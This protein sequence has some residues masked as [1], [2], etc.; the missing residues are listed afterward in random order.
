MPLEDP[1]HHPLRRRPRHPRVHA[2]RAGPRRQR[3]LARPAER[4]LRAR[5]HPLPPALGPPALRGH[6]ARR[7]LAWSA[8]GPPA[9]ALPRSSSGR[10]PVPAELVAICERAMRR[11]IAIATPAPSRSRGTSWPSSTAR[12]RREQALARARSGARAMEPDRWPRERG[13]KRRRG[14]RRAARRGAALRSDR[15]EAPG[16]GAR[17]RGRPARPRVAALARDAVAPG[18][19]RRAHRRP[20]PARGARACSPT[21]TASASRRRSWPPGRGRGALRGA[22]PRPRPR[23]ARSLP[24]RRGRDTLVTDPPGAEVIARALRAAR[25]PARARGPAGML[26]R[27]PLREVP[28]SSGGATGSGCARRD[29]PRCSIRC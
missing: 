12:E 28:L 4:R 1:G 25:P 10:P 2:A 3:D 17:G 19:A 27:T 20:G 29:G 16:V 9:A 24:P 22:P 6:A 18:R 5:R 23:P 7:V 8:D 26:G 21:T 13:A 14:R 15:K 11:E